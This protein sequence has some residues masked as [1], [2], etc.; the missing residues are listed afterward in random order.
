[1]ATMNVTQSPLLSEVE[2]FLADTGMGASYFGRRAA[3]NTELV[4]RL[5]GE[6]PGRGRIWPETEQAVREFMAEHRR[7][8]GS[9]PKAPQVTQTDRG[10]A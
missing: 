3:K 9:A 2:Q 4:S 6:K 7:A 5:R 8:H 10:A 1:M